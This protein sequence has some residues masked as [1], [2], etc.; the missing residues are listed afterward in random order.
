[1]SADAVQG[2]AVMDREA[3]AHGAQ[4]H[5]MTDHE[6]RGRVVQARDRISIGMSEALEIPVLAAPLVA[7]I[8]VH[9]KPHPRSARS[10]VLA[11]SSRMISVAALVLLNHENASSILLVTVCGSTQ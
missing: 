7:T 10:V 11:K 6:A 8:A 9:G 2:H 1:M 3:Q 5:E 4:L